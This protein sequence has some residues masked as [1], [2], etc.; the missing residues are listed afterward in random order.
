MWPRDANKCSKELFK[1]QRCER[2]KHAAQPT[3]Q[4]SVGD[5]S[6]ERAQSGHYALVADTVMSVPGS[7]D[8][9]VLV[10]YM[11]G[12][13]VFANLFRVTPDG[14]EIWRAQPPDTGPDAWTSARI[15]GDEVIAFSWS[16]F[17]VR[18]DLATGSELSRVF[19][20]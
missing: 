13:T 1:P 18:L 4:A 3:A 12:P 10:D 11:G 19:T 6:T 7:E 14:A 17:A 20:K 8:T 2:T 16:C 15:E 9:V 5:H